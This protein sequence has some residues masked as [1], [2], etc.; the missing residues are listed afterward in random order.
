MAKFKTIILNNEYSELYK[1]SREELKIAV[2]KDGYEICGV[3]TP[4][5]KETEVFLVNKNS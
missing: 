1:K 2:E 5:S 4:F 3:V